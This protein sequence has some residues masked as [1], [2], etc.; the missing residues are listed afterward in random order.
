[1]MLA[2]PFAKTMVIAILAAIY[3]FAGTLGLKLASVHVITTAVWP[4]T[5]IT[6]AALLLLGY[7]V[8]PGIFLG[9]FLVNV[10]TEGTIATSLG[11]AV[12]NTLEGLTGAYLVN[13]FAGG[14]HVFDRPQ[15]VLRFAVLAGMVSTAVSATIGVTSLAF[16]G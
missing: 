7:R 4:P 13:R 12:G 3:F 8:W 10:T 2:R 11:I 9:A 1:M 16:G 5:G 15:D 6:L 14:R